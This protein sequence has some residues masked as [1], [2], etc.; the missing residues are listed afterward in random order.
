MYR[1]SSCSCC[2]WLDWSWPG[3]LAMASRWLATNC[4]G[5]VA[6]SAGSWLYSWL[7]PVKMCDICE[8][9]GGWA[10]GGG[11]VG[12]W[13]PSWSWRGTTARLSSC[14][15]SDVSMRPAPWAWYDEIAWLSSRFCW[16]V[17]YDVSTRLGSCSLCEARGRLS[18]QSWLAESTWLSSQSWEIDKDPP[19]DTEAESSSLLSCS[20]NSSS[21]SYGERGHTYSLS[22]V[23]PMRITAQQTTPLASGSRHLRPT[24]SMGW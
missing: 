1:A 12:G 2:R 3:M 15:W 10:S 23:T 18:S 13:S 19:S 14:S 8:V 22:V 4:A 24:V 20:P 9:T 11:R 16:D 7:V 5:L 17:R 6:S 21:W